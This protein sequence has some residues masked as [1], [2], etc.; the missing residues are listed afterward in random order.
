MQLSGVCAS[1]CLSR[2]CRCCGSPLNA[3]WT[4]DID[5]LLPGAQQQQRV[6]GECEQC[7]LTADVGNG[8]QTC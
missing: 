3:R 4:G 6:V 5:G 7:H 2:Q 1:V 8:T